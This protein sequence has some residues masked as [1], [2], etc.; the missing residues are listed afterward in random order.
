M[1][2]IYRYQDMRIEIMN[3]VYV[4]CRSLY[5]KVSTMK[6]E[7]VKILDIFGLSSDC[8]FDNFEDV[9]DY[10]MHS[11]LML[12]LNRRT[13]PQHFI[14][15]LI[16]R[17]KWSVGDNDIDTFLSGFDEKSKIDIIYDIEL[18]KLNGIVI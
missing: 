7:E 15:E 18:L 1:S 16:S 6:A 14:D 17:M 4:Y 3:D 11:L 2:E 12:I 9:N 8:E 10:F 5:G 13:G